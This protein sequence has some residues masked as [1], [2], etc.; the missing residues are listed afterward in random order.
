M[1]ADVLT[2]VIIWVLLSVLI[3]WLMR[4]SCLV[5]ELH[6]RLL[7]VTT[8]VRQLKNDLRDDQCW[9]KR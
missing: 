6:A 5:T 1:P 7:E 9:G 3:F 8:E 2:D 4:L